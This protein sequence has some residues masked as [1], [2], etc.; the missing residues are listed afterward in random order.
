MQL[1][2]VP[3]PT[4]KP[5]EILVRVHATSVTRGDTELRALDV[6]WLFW[7]PLRIWI[8]LRRP[9]P[10]TILGMELAGTVEATGSEVSRFAP[11]DAVFGPTRMGFGGYAEY[12][13]VVADE[14]IVRKPEG[15]SFSQA[16]AVGVGGLAALGYL[17]KGGIDTAKTVLIRGASGSIGSFAIQLAKH[18]GAHVTA[19]CPPDS[20][21]S[22]ASLGA[23]VVIDYTTDDFTKNGETYDLILD[24]VGKMSISACLGSLASRGRYVRATIPGLWEIARALW[25]AVTSS[26]RIVMGD[27]GDSLEGLEYLA[28]LLQTGELQA[29]VDRHYPLAEIAEAHRYVQRGHKRGNVIVTVCDSHPASDVATDVQV[30]GAPG[31]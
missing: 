17:R 10:N 26:K 11:G 27:A 7:I 20:V 5:G 14:V 9:K 2:D 15:V 4:P 30:P 8:G 28:G 12:T 6:P 25:T 21:Q 22:V 16:A 18:F 3:K 23:D 24:V 29:V 13:C 1:Q 19:V 31:H